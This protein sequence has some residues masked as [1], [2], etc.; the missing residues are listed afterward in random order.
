[1]CQFTGSA[2]LSLE[3][4]GLRCVL[5]PAGAA[6]VS[7]SA[8]AGGRW[9]PVALTPRSH[10]S[11]ESDPS[12]AGRIIAP[13]C[14][15]VRA[16][17]AIIGGARV[18]LEQNEG[19]NHLH[20]GFHSAALL[21]WHSEQRS[22]SQARFTLA[23]PDDLGGYPGNRRLTADYCLEGNSLT[24]R[25]RAV[26]DRPTWLDMTNHVYWDLSGRFDGSAMEQELHVSAARYVR[27]DAAHLPVSI[28]PVQ[29]T[30]F[31]FT[32]PVS[33][34]EMMRRFPQ[35]EQLAIARGF[36]NALLL[37]PS[38]QKKN[39]FAARLISHKTGIQMT[40]QTDQPTVVF[41]SGG[42][43]GAQ[44][45]LAHGHCVPGCALALEAQGLPDPFHLPGH[46]PAMLLPGSTWERVISWRFES[47]GPSAP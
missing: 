28:C 18:T 24:L 11:G 1:M 33:P 25:C 4:E 27:N 46:A 40:M 8:R 10:F 16:G 20:G 39:G 3:G 19:S 37:E 32:S 17:E 9:L 43:L 15:R 38:L 30:A 47:I 29:G 6:I 13:C 23:L 14:G 31:D 42:F 45:P 22:A 36:N 5:S 2:L 41:Y 21:R 26:T 34:G 35:E 44:T 7:L 12:L